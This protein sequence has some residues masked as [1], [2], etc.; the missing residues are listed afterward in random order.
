M[1]ELTEKM[2]EACADANDSFDADEIAE[3]TPQ[4]NEDWEVVDDHHLERKF[5][6]DDFQQALDFINDVGELAENENHHPDLYLTWGEAKVTIWTHSVD[7]L[8]EADFIFAAKTD[9][10]AS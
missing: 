2:C 1:S 10:I 8:T 6:F 3:Y 4:I 9:E 5:D 7:G